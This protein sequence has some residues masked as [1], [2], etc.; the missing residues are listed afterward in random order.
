MNK[1]ELLRRLEERLAHGEISEKTYLDI[2]ARYD[3]M[4]D[5][6]PEAPDAPDAVEPPA[7]PTPPHPPIADLGTMIERSIESVLEQVASSLEGV[8]ESGEIDRRMKEVSGHVKDALSRIGTQVEAGGRR[9]VIRGSGVVSG[10]Q[11]IDEFKCAGSGRVTGTLRAREAHVSGA[12]EIEGDCNSREFHSSGKTRIQGSARAREFHASGKVSV[13][14]DL[15]AQEVA[16]AGKVDVGGDIRDAED[17]SIS[18]MVKVAGG[19]KARE[20]ASRGM[21]EIGKDLEAEEVAIHL[22]GTSRVPR[23]V[24]REVTVRRGERNGE[25]IVETIEADEVYVESTRAKLI[26]GREVRVGPYSVVDAV[27]PA[28]LEVHETATVK[29]RRTLATSD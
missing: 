15:V 8:A 4:G 9:I 19:V 1:E 6:P 29:E 26:R 3:A 23:I 20:F 16:V 24:A 12:C 14:G 11:T 13:A 10:D 21:F 5:A 18:G 7:P 28:D 17:V 2:K 25:L 22:S 27:E